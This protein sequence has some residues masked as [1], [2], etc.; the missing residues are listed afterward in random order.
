MVYYNLCCSTISRRWCHSP[1]FS[2]SPLTWFIRTSAA[3]LLVA[4]GVMRPVFIRAAEVLIN[5]VSAEKL[6]TGLMTPSA[7]N[8]TAAEVL[9]NHVCHA[10][11]IQCFSTDMVY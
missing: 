5:H 1:V 2:V 11:S 6:Y 7:T 10:S 9:I 8:S 3:V 4:E